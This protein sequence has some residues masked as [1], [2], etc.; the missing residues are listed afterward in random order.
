MKHMF[1]I[2]HLEKRCIFLQKGLT[3]KKFCAARFL[4]KRALVIRGSRCQPLITRRLIMNIAEATRSRLVGAIDTMTPTDFSK[5]P[6][7]HFIRN[8]KLPFQA[9]LLLKISSAKGSLPEE[10]RHFHVSKGVSPEDAPSN[11]LISSNAA[12]SPRMHF[13]RCCTS[14]MMHAALLHCSKAIN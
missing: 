14:S 7:K 6:G 13:R 1:Y 10:I 12:N 8:R 2:L 11:L 9:L 4:R 3:S 5:D